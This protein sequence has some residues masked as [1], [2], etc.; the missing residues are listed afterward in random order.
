MGVRDGLVR[1]A[2]GQVEERS[3]PPGWLAAQ[4]ETLNYGG[5][6][7]AVPTTTWSREE[8]PVVLTGN[9]AYGD[10]GVVFAVEQ[11]RIQ[12]FRQASFAFKRF[13][14][15]PKPMAA[16]LFRSADLA[17]LD[18]PSKLLARM[19]LDADVAGNAFAVR[20]GD[21]LRLLRPQWCT[22]VSGSQR[23]PDDPDV[24]WDAEPI[25]LIYSPK[26]GNASSV[27]TFGW[28]EVAHFAPVEDPEAR[29]R[30][31]S[32]M[33]PVLGEAANTTAFNAYLA[34]YWSHN[35]T[36]NMAVTF[37]PEVQKETV[38]AFRDVFLQRHQGVERAFRTAFL[39]GG[40][41]LK[42]IGTNLK[43]L[44]AKEISADQFARICAA[45]G[46]PPIV[47]TIVPGLESA[48]TYS[49]YASAHRAF[50]D[51]T[52]RPL[53]IEAVR[54]LSKLIPA[55]TGSELWYDVSGV[56][57]LQADALDD[58][59]VMAQQAM[60]MRTLVDGGFVPSTV[61]D[62]VTTGDMTK[63]QHSGLLSVQ[64][65]APGTGASA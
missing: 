20:D 14:A 23:Q 37:P 48:S 54:A 33:R 5:N 2:G 41:D 62:A 25:G 28:S 27:E 51:L 6:L 36:P 39:G 50:A 45:G 17:P 24:A 40:A 47:V 46:V 49:N 43:D 7:Y 56:S 34:R 38:E 12:L 18:N 60:T 8:Q 11:R 35:A 30:G 13:G 31:M 58:A 57:A 61:I 26:S 42:L 10:N 44:A 59:N 4:L 15:G 53:W 16:D 22:I 1:L 63:L 29:W 32:W 55:P 19:L 65:Q 9:R 21:R 64:T 52:M 3:F